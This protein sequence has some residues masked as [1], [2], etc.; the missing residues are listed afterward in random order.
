VVGDGLA[1][2]TAGY[3]PVRPVYAVRPGQ[4]GD[5]SLPKGERASKAIA[6][7]HPRGG[8]YIPSPI[9]YRGQLFTCNN[10]GILTVY[11]AET[12]EQLSQLRLSAAGASFSASPVA[13]DGRLYIAGETGEVYVLRAGP[14]PELLAVHPMGEPVMST[15]AIS[16]GLLVLRTL[17]HVFGLAQPT[18]EHRAAP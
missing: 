18:A 10:N 1:F 6:W 2:V 13:A 16:G 15:P 7:S 8:T 12:G 17:N 3:P 11:R 14:E 4:R 5:L 9:L